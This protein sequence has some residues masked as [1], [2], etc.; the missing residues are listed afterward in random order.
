[1]YQRLIAACGFAVVFMS[2]GSAVQSAPAAGVV[3][4][5]SVHFQNVES[6]VVKVHGWH[7]SCRRGPAR[8]HRHV[9]G[10]GNVPCRRAGGYH[11]SGPRLNRCGVV[12]NRCYARYGRGSRAYYRCMKRAGC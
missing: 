2:A 10:R 6:Q 12:Y 8:W 5:P 9:R 11:R 3:T 4:A 1:M 7:S